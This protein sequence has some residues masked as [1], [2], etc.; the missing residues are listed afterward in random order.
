MSPGS[1]SGDPFP[2]MRVVVDVGGRRCFRDKEVSGTGVS[3][4]ARPRLGAV[5]GPDPEEHPHLNESLNQTDDSSDGAGSRAPRANANAH[6]FLAR[7]L[8]GCLE[9]HDCIHALKKKYLNPS[10][11]SG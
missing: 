8:P 9:F 7:V 1:D 11:T 5:W 2:V 10:C 6:A 4:R 3:R